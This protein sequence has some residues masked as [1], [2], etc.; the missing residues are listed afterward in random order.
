MSEWTWRLLRAGLPI[1]P[2]VLARRADKFAC[3]FRYAIAVRIF[4]H[5]V[6]LG[7]ND[8]EAHLDGVQ[9]IAADAAIENFLRPSCGVEMP[10]VLR[11]HERNRHRPLVLADHEY[12]LGVTLEHEFV[13]VV[14]SFDKG[15]AALGV[16]DLVT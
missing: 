9:F 5:I 15:L 12:C 13:S 7:I 10:T 6:A 1:E 3:V 8:R 2:V 16:G 14:I 11:F 4:C